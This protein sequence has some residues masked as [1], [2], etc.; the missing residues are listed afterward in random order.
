LALKDDALRERLSKAAL[1]F[2]RGF[3]WEKC[4]EAF[5]NVIG[6]HIA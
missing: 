3:S 6:H 5:L 2:S 4:A 1:R